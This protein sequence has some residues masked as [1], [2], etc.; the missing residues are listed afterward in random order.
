MVRI[1]AEKADAREVLATLGLSLELVCLEPVFAGKSSKQDPVR[2]LSCW[3]ANS[4]NITN[5]DK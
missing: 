1:E 3:V 5:N 2:F 4:N